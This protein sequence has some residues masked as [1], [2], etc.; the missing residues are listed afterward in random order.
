MHPK[1]SEKGRS[2]P[3]TNLG[4]VVKLQDVSLHGKPVCRT[5]IRHVETNVKYKLITLYNP[6][7]ENVK[8]N[9]L[10]IKTK[11]NMIE[12]PKSN[13]IEEQENELAQK[14]EAGSYLKKQAKTN[15]MEQDKILTHVYDVEVE[16]KQQDKDN[17]ND[18]TMMNVN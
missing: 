13:A 2:I 12:I 1:H 11:N 14:N 7:G 10:L 16:S 9:I 18:N 3:P 15:N 8:R 4:N 6:L 5:A 17:S